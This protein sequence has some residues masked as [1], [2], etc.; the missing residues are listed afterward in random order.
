MTS[1]YAVRISCVAVWGCSYG[2]PDGLGDAYI[3]RTRI[4]DV[5]TSV[6]AGRIPC[7]TVW[8]GRVC[9]AIA[10]SWET[11]AETAGAEF[12]SIIIAAYSGDVSEQF[13]CESSPRVRYIEPLKLV[14]GIATIV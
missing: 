14:Q 4:H 12:S 8:G 13:C 5:M 10:C 9:S 1:V 11:G 7:V 3:M 2:W 6:Y